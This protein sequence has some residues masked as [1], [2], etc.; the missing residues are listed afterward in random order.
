MGRFSTPKERRQR[1]RVLPLSPQIQRGTVP[2][3]CWHPSKATWNGA[4]L[5]TEGSEI[6]ETIAWTVRKNEA[7]YGTA[8]VLAS[9]KGHP[10]IVKI[11]IESGALLDTEG[12]ETEE[13]IAGT[14]HTNTA[15]HGTALVLASL[16]GNLDIVKILVENGAFLYTE[17]WEAEGENVWRGTALEVV[18]ADGHFEIV[19]LLAKGGMV[20]QAAEGGEALAK[21]PAETGQVDHEHDETSE[22]GRD[23]D[24]SSTSG[25]G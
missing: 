10:E 25:D 8:L 19:E 6:D 3:W 18:S 16:K 22:V 5:D 2:R 13:T 7:R 17:G 4:L 1:S 24:G 23:D 21:I 20:L 11:L 14:V 15:R 9:L 12:R